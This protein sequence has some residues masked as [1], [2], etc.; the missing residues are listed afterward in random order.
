MG[1][2]ETIDCFICMHTPCICSEETKEIQRK[3]EDMNEEEQ[4][5]NR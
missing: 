1:I 2:E 3:T 4:Y 5:L